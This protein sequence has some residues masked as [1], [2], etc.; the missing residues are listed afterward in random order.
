MDDIIYCSA[1]KGYT[2]LE[3]KDGAKITISQTLSHFAA[4]LDHN[5][6]QISQSRIVNIKYLQVIEKSKRSV[7]LSNGVSLPF[8]YKISNI[9]KRLKAA[10]TIS[11]DKLNS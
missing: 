7:S 1:D 5:F 3:I 8:T 6:V 2:T 9:C 10:L 4:N 11:D